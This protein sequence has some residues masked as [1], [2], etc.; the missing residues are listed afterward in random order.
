MRA[1]FSLDLIQQKLFFIYAFLSELKFRHLL[2]EEAVGFINHSLDLQC[3]S[4]DWFL[5]K[6]KTTLKWI[7]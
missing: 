3:K 4:N 2:Y 6:S 5:Y 1:I 7:K